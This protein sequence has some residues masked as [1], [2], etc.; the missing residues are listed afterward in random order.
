MTTDTIGGVWTFAIELARGLCKRGIE[1]TL[2]AMGD[3]PTTGQLEEVRRID[4][5]A[6]EARPYRLE[7]MEDPWEDIA[8]ASM[9]LTS[10]ADRDRPDLV[11][12]NTLAHGALPWK[13]PV[14]SVGHSCVSSWFEA[15][16]DQRAPVEWDHYRDVVQRSLGASDVVAAPSVAMMQALLRHHSHST[17]GSNSTA[18]S[19][20]RSFRRTRVIYNGRD[21]QMFVPAEPQQEV[22]CAGRLWDEAKNIRAVAEAAADIA[23]PVVVA[24]SDTHPDGGK[25]ELDGVDMLG[26][27]DPSALAE[28]YARSTI[29]ALPARYEPF[30]LTAL[31]A[32]LAGNVLVLGDIATLREIWSEA[33]LFVDPEQP[34]ELAE[35][36]NTLISDPERCRFLA[37]RAR[38][39]ALELSAEVMVENYLEVYEEMSSAAD[40][41]TTDSGST[42]LSSHAGGR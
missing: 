34:G 6:L 10:L 25:I 23:W 17:V 37:G 2:A 38:R 41:R 28:R 15:V 24:G 19:R 26:R 5:L 33:A 18:D 22:L 31:E 8:E 13:A 12:L 20:G 30:G 40:L 4:G 42:Q 39:R 7:W 35:T 32:A 27:L 1:I 36:I 14:L 9:W 11:H 21:P 16:K 29:Y 3:E